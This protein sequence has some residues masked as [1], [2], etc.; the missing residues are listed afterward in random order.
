[1]VVAPGEIACGG[2]AK[3][4]RERGAGVTRT[5]RVML[6]LRTQKEPVEAFVGADRVNAIGAA[7]EHLV[8]IALVGD[9]E[10]K[11]VLGRGKHAVQRDAQLDDAEVRA[12][13]AAGLRKRG[14]ERVAYLCRQIR[15]LRIGNFFD[16]IGGLDRLQERTEGGGLRRGGCHH[17]RWRPVIRTGKERRPGCRFWRVIRWSRCAG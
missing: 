3:R 4:G 1:M 8:D 15:Q 16:I 6:R 7:G 13:V 2:H 5:I 12:E 9:I 11:L 10:D 14:D 17:R